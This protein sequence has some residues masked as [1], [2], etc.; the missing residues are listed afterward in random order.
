M[1][2]IVLIVAVIALFGCNKSNEINDQF[3]LDNGIEF[4]V[5]NSIDEDLLDTSM[6]NHY[7]V[8]GIKLF[9]KVNGKTNEVYNSEMDNPRNYK[10]YK[11]ENEYR[12][13]VFMNN[14]ETSEKPVTYIQWN[15][16][17]TDTI[18]VSYERTGNAILKRKVWLNGKQIWDRALNKEEYYQLIK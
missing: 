17:D 4:S 2:K 18:E 7:E 10:I 9:Y 8:N 14:T 16:N 1:K 12:I 6:P 3:N 15:N 13:R 5:F 11:H